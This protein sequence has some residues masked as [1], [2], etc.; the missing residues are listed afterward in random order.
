MNRSQARIAGE[1]T[2]S[3]GRPCKLGHQS[4][5][6]TSNGRCIECSK[7]AFRK[8]NADNSEYNIE[9]S[10]K[11]RENNIEKHLHQSRSRASKRYLLKKADCL[12]YAKKYRSIEENRQKSMARAREWTALNPE[13]V[14]EHKRKNEA[15]RRARKFNV[16]G[17]FR[18]NDIAELFE[19]QNGK[20]AYFQYCGH[21][22]SG[23]KYQ[24]DH[25]NPLA[26][27]GS[28]TKENLQLL[29]R[30]C[31]ARKGARDPSQFAAMIRLIA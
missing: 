29:C 6:W 8:W 7:A 20:C 12:S 2:Y 15:R 31:N 26:R 30:S 4:A 3:L 16:G 13:A 24:I 17:T 5:R 10:R 27:G 28:N 1:K 14:R 18:L 23:S 22:F 19:N 25:I 9:R 21:V 11:W